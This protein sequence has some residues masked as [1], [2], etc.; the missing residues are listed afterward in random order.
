VAIA[1]ALAT[2][3]DLIVCDEAV[4]ALDVSVQGTILD[5]CRRLQ[6]ERGLAF[7][8]ITHDLG[9]VR[10]IADRAVVMLKGEICHAGGVESLFEDDAHPY[11]KALLAAVP[12]KTLDALPQGRTAAQF[13]LSE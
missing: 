3:P 5:L 7:L 12:G 8:F 6:A 9:V 1:R 10:Q 2:E 11:V 4:S 13:V